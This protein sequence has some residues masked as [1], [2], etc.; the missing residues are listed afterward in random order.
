M[1][2]SPSHINQIFSEKYGSVRQIDLV[3]SEET[4]SSVKGRL[5]TLI[6]W[7]NGE[8][9][10]TVGREEIH[11]MNFDDETVKVKRVVQDLLND[12]SIPRVSELYRTRGGPTQM[13]K[14]SS[15]VILQHADSGFDDTTFIEVTGIEDH[16]RFS[17]QTSLDNWGSRSDL[18]TAMDAMDTYPFQGMVT[19]VSKEG[20]GPDREDWAVNYLFICSP[21][22][23]DR[24]RWYNEQNLKE[25][26]YEETGDW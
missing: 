14:F 24:K 1:Y 10:G 17:G 22:V 20:S 26:L 5:G 19:P 4:T 13:Y 12:E 25:E 23:E 3:S 2:A 15:E 11:Q 6:A 18:Q 9:S 7:I 21:S 16:V 8:F